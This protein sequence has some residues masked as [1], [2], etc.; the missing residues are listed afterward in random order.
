MGR[1]VQ[2]NK[3]PY[4]ILGVAPRNFYGTELFYA[5]DFWVPLVDQGQVDG[6]SGLKSRGNRD[7][8]V[9]GHLKAGVTPAQAT[10]D[11]SAVG[12]YLS[13]TYPKDDDGMSF[14]LARPGLAGDM[15]GKPGAGVSC[16]ADGA[17]GVDSSGRVRESWQFVCRSRG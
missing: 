13:K 14:K 2:L 12:A 16:G 15:L 11:L 8:E 5:P 1:A 17:G 9:V 3:H 10:A 6:W 7:L 4:T